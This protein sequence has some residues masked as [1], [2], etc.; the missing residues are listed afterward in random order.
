M[1]T[2]LKKKNK[3]KK[4]NGK[5]AE[6]NEYND[7]LLEH[8]H[9]ELLEERERTAKFE[10]LVGD[11]LEHSRKGKKHIEQLERHIKVLKR[12]LA[13]AEAQVIVTEVALKKRQPPALARKPKKRTLEE[14]MMFNPSEENCS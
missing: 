14:L 8:S 5:L 6:Y 3:L 1:T 9:Q 12:K 11:T 2:L 13:A 4:E 10:K 7:V